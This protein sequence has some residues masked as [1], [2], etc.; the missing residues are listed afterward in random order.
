MYDRTIIS[1]PAFAAEYGFVGSSDDVSSQPDSL[2]SDDSP[3]TS[4]VDT[5]MNRRMRPCFLAA[6]SSTCVPYVLFI[7]NAIEFPNELST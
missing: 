4:S 3:Y 6:S 1:A 7:V 2:P 5:L